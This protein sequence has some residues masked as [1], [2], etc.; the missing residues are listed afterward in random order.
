MEVTTH[1]GI[2]YKLE[3]LKLPL[4]LKTLDFFD[5]H[6]NYKHLLTEIIDSDDTKD[7]RIIKILEW[8]YAS[9]V[10]SPAG[11]PV[12]DDHVWNIIVRGYGADDQLS[13]VFATLCNYAGMKAFFSY[14]RSIDRKSVVVLSF[15][16]LAGRWR[17]F[18]PYRGIYF[19]NNDGYFAS[20]E[21][22]RQGNWKIKSL[23]SSVGEYP[24]YSQYIVNLT[25]KENVEIR[26]AGIQ[27]PLNRLL[28]EG[29]KYFNRLAQWISKSEN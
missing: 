15:V 13:D 29:E 14:V 21:D 24:D 4:Y 28:F 10:K 7:D 11:L 5:R 23:D 25:D 26:R 1:R 6:Y 16:Q 27:S 9:I 18:D 12:V 3:T 22:L 19:L 8:T 17:V 20:I 2:N